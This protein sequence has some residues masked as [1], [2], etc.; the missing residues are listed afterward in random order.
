MLSARKRVG[1]GQ[2]QSVENGTEAQQ[3]KWWGLAV[4]KGPNHHPI[5]VG[6]AS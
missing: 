1:V 2:I 5:G 3:G 6:A 4:S